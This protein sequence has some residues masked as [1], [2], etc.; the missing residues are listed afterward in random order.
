MDK[1]SQPPSLPTSPSEKRLVLRNENLAAFRDTEQSEFLLSGAAGTGKSSA[2]LARLHLYCATNPN[3]RCLM[4]RKT[5]KSLTEAG[6]VTFESIAG[7]Y[8]KFFS[9]QKREQRHAYNYPNGSTIVI[10]GMDDPVKIMSTDFDQI[11]VQEAVELEENDW[12]SLTTR[13]RNGALPNQQLFG[14]TNPSFP[15][16]WLKRRCD[17]GKTKLYQTYHEDNPAYFDSKLNTWTTRGLKYIEK[18]DA[19]SGAR[20][21]RLRYGRWV[22]AEGIVYD[23]W[24]SRIH[25]INP[26]PIPRDWPRYVGVDFGYRDPFS[27]VWFAEDPD[28]RLYL[29]REFYQTGKLVE[30][31]GKYIAAVSRQEPAPKWIVCDHDLGDRMTLEKYLGRSTVPA[32]KRKTINHGI[33]LMKSRL[34]VQGDGRPRFYVMRDCLV[35]R[36]RDLAEVQKKPTS[37]IEEIESYVWKDSTLKEQPEDANNHSLDSSRYVITKRDRINS[38]SFEPTFIG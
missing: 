4:V 9:Q 6:L 10:G 25:L 34:C 30:D 15:T 32:D 3:V 28:G 11:Y 33:D 36:D 26:F 29:Y 37:F 7:D 20:K 35:Y 21:E 14:D 22:Q 8:R 27:V 38:F 13:L 16:H 2:L 17:L 24:D 5:R 23:N 12:E 19:L 18:L 31:V 1:P